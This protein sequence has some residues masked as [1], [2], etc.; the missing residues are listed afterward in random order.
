MEGCV[1]QRAVRRIADDDA[2]SV[3][4]PAEPIQRRDDSGL[5]ERGCE[6]D[7][8]GER[9]TSERN[10]LAQFEALVAESVLAPSLPLFPWGGRVV[11]WDRLGVFGFLVQAARSPRWHCTFRSVSN[12]LSPHAMEPTPVVLP[13]PPL[14]PRRPGEPPTVDI[15]E[16]PDPAAPWDD[17]EP[18]EPPTPRPPELP[19]E[20]DQ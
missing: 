6:V 13:D 4:S 7:V 2:D 8:P 12:G 3:L 14:E 1:F 20:D 10:A 5:G 17:P 18:P 11:D 15:P 9:G 19:S 16:P